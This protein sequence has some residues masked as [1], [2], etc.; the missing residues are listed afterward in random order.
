[1]RFVVLN[2]GKNGALNVYVNALPGQRFSW[3]S[4]NNRRQIHGLRR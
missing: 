1:M 3:L 2:V 4:S